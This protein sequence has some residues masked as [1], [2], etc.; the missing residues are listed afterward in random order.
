MMTV[1]CWLIA[2]SV[3]IHVFPFEIKTAHGSPLNLALLGHFDGWQ[4]FST[5]Y[6]SCASIEVSIAN[7]S[8]EDRSHVDEVYVV[9][10]L[11]STSVPNDLPEGLDPF[12]QPLMD[13]LCE[14]FIDGFQVKY[15]P[16]IE[17][18]GYETG[19]FETVRVL[20]LCWSG[21][22]PGQCEIGK[23]LNQGK[24]ACRRCKLIGQKSD[25]STHYY[26]GNNRYHCRYPW[27]NRDIQ[28]EQDN[29]FD[30]DN[31]TRKSMRKKQSS[32]KGF[33]G[34][35]LLHKYLYPLYGFDILHHMV[36]DIFHTVPLNVCRNQLQRVLELELLDTSYLDEEIK[37]FPWTNELKSGRIPVQI[38]RECK[39]LGQ[40][41]AESFQKFSFPFLECVMEGKLADVNELEIQSSISRFTELH[42]YS[43]RDGWND[44]MIDIQRK[45]AQRINIKVEESQGLEMCTI[46]LHNMIHVHEDIMNFSAT[47][48]Y[49]CAVFERAVKDYVKRSQNCKGVEVTY[50]KAE[51]HREFLKSVQEDNTEDCKNCDISQVLILY[52]V[53][54]SKKCC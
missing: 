41:K 1:Y 29:L 49:W 47:D 50:A 33:T 34:T 9:G 14:G 24:C 30:L 16:G 44:D 32:D 7:M 3:S 54:I 4:P 40:W 22:H 11:P 23:F 42:F 6:R 51:A 26:Y 2:Q 46:S 53:M 37:N 17:I 52:I 20:L 13:D 15:P 45:L 5:S 28:L 19:E 18:N 48:N 12:L 8:K 38:G 31:E 39:G 36:I 10:F 25:C 35:S 21:D 27:G 43:G